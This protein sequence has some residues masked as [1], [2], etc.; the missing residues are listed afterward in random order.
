LSTIPLPSRGASANDPN[1]EGYAIPYRR[2]YYTAEGHNLM[3][4]PDDDDPGEKGRT[5]N[6]KWSVLAAKTIKDR[7]TV[8]FKVASD[9]FRAVSSTGGVDPEERLHAPNEWYWHLN[10]KAGF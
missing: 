3:T 5:D 2:F 7:F 1:Y 4:D 9:H 6:F 10:F 8:T